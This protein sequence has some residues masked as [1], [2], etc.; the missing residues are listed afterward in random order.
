M[1]TQNQVLFIMLLT[2]SL[3]YCNSSRLTPPDIY[4]FIFPKNGGTIKPS[5]ESFVIGDKI[6]LNAVPFSGH[7]FYKW[8]G[9][10]NS[11]DSIIAIRVTE[12][13]R[14]YGVIFPDTVIAEG[15]IIIGNFP[16]S[17]LNAGE[18]A[19][20]DLGID[21]PLDSTYNVYCICEKYD[22]FTI[23]KHCAGN[24][25]GIQVGCMNDSATIQDEWTLTIRSDKSDSLIVSE[26]I[27]YA[28]EWR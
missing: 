19:Y 7:F 1:K 17:V 18:Y 22:Y 28:V 23:S 3:F 27:Q 14:G 11:I 8:Y 26:K 16:D 4:L 20:F 25:M 13:R 10:T 5:Q 9:D 24:I 6:E 12:N 21:V 15:R 2:V